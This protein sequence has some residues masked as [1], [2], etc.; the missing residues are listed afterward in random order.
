M[1]EDNKEEIKIEEPKKKREYI[2]NEITH[3]VTWKTGHRSWNQNSLQ[4]RTGV[5]CEDHPGRLNVSKCPDSF[6]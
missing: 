2:W 4:M 6:I 5:I 1:M 3:G